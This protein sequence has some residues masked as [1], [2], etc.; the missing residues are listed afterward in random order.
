MRHR[1]FNSVFAAA[2]LTALI[3]IVSI[4][5]LFFPFMEN[6][7]LGEL[8]EEARLLVKGIEVEGT[9][10]LDMVSEKER[11][12]TLIDTNGVVAFDSGTNPASLD[13]HINREEIRE[14][15]RT[16]EGSSIRFSDTLTCRTIYYATRM[17]D[18]RV[19]RV[20]VTQNYLI[21][22]FAW[23]IGPALVII[24]AIIFFSAFFARRVSDN[25]L[26]PLYDM[27]PED[28]E[29]AEIYEEI[30]PLTQKIL[31]QNRRIKEKV[32]RELEQKRRKQYEFTANM[33]HELKTPLTSISG[34]AEL[35]MDGDVDRD[36]MQDFA[37]SIHD[38]SA[39]LVGL[40]NDII[41]ISELEEWGDDDAFGEV[42]LRDVADEVAERLAFSAKR[43]GVTIDV[44]ADDV[45]VYGAEEILFEI[46]YNLCD[47]AIKYNVSGGRVSMG[48]RAEEGGAC[49]F[50]RDTGIGIPK[51]EQERV[52]DRFYMVD[53]SHSKEVGGT[54]LGLSIVRQ[55]ALI[56]GASIRVDST[57]GSGTEIALYFPNTPNEEGAPNEDNTPNEEGTPN[58]DNTL[59]KEGTPNREGTPN[60]ER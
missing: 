36:T 19:L 50:V 22:M 10:F 40:V 58:D 31:S 57:D 12:I 23:L 29:D 4:M 37:H 60:E 30:R 59:N 49:F 21:A 27:D 43:K 35:M 42:R 28:P 55:G 2:A 26:R 14:A 1:I 13:N 48:A 25:I 16:G 46:V 39:R 3:T 24:T 17:G 32:Y 33:T 53:K 51:E 9:G 52:F 8:Q 5:L 7:I 41:K 20:S 45:A 38:E 54:G 34:F 11:R 18:G 56:H 6:E 44:A 47:N 15:I